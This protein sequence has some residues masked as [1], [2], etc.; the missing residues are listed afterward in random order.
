M[1]RYPGAVWKP[2]GKQTQPRL[3][4][5][6][7]ILLHT[8]GGGT[9]ES[10]DR[11]FRIGGYTGLESHFGIGADGETWEWQDTDYTA[12]ADVTAN[13]YAW[14]IETEDAGHAFPAWTGSNVPA[15]TAAQCDSIIR[16]VAWL[17]R[18][19]DI[20]A[21]HVPDSKPG[22]HGIAGH[23]Q[24]INSSPAGQKGYRQPG[25][26]LWS[27]VLGKVCPGDR[28][29]AQID[30]VIVPGVI[31]ALRPVNHSS[32]YFNLET[33]EDGMFL[34]RETGSSAVYLVW[35]GYRSWIQ[36]Q[37]I[38]G[39]WQAYLKAKGLND[40]VIEVPAGDLAGITTIGTPHA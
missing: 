14:S 15:W 4:K 21:V 19:G 6:R 10:T 36:K 1:A 28:R 2:L 26:D 16:L 37:S 20:P 13:A 40:Q 25:G 12:D 39:A 27:D 31:A 33:S 7:I 35:P 24:G 30:S 9:L 22:R 38:L 8:M 32:V 23:R 34:A 3:L 29:Y 11:E 5:P 17:C 18:L